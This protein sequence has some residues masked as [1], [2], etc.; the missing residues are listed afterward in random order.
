LRKDAKAIA[1]HIVKLPLK[2][3]CPF[4][5]TESVWREVLENRGFE[6]VTTD[7]DFFTT[8]PPDGVQCIISNPPFSMKKEVLDRIKQLNLRFA[9]ILPYLWLND[10]VP[11]DYGHQIMLFRKRM[12]F[13][14]PQGNLNK[15]RT[16][17]FVLSDGLLTSDL[18]VIREREENQ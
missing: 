1:D 8:S 5:D 9:L 13:N 11:L 6:V 15:P 17:C 14:T 3:W 18:I 10:C 2:V 4:N 12:H 16:N 7:T